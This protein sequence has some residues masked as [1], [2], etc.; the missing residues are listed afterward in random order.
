M[1][2]TQQNTGHIGQSLRTLRNRWLAAAAC[3]AVAGTTAAASPSAGFGSQ[4]TPI[5]GP[6]LGGH[7][8]IVNY[9]SEDSRRLP[10]VPA[11]AYVVA[12]AGSGAVLAA[13]DPHGRYRPASTLKVLTAITLM[14]HL[15][16]NAMVTAS[17]AAADVTP[18]KVGL[19][20]GDKYRVSDLYKALLMISANDA[21]IALAKASGSY[22]HAMAMMNAEAHHLR[23]S[24]TVAKTPNGLDAK[25][26]HVSA[27]D[28]ALFARQALKIPVF[29]HDERLLTAKFPVR[30]HHHPVTLWNQNTMLQTFPG[31]LG[32][33]IGWTTP[34]KATFI[35]WARRDG[36][37]LIVTIL[38]CTPLTEMTYAARLLRWGFAMDGKVKPIG[39]LVA[40]LGS[41]AGPLAAKGPVK[42]KGPVK[43]KTIVPQRAAAHRPKSA[44]RSGTGISIPAGPLAAGAGAV[45]VAV[46]AAFAVI[47]LTKRR[48]TTSRILR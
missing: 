16:P 17:R 15:N 13:K 37:T 41:A 46:L 42:H 21:A 40:P 48:R 4:P 31:D 44:A 9:P 34:A 20:A 26:Q 8:V 5:G 1:I 28:E 47:G 3:L 19:I 2:N 33:K 14:P 6:Q 7:G 39:H 45:A 22:D 10:S 24:D 36:R 32:G 25:G 12:D 11:S 30:P 23:A 35:G 43:V 29:M 27:Y 38:H 18:S